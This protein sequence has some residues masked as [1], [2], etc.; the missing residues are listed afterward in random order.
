MAN[1]NSFFRANQAIKTGFNDL[2]ERYGSWIGQLFGDK[3]IAAIRSIRANQDIM[4]AGTEEQKSIAYFRKLLNTPNGTNSIPE[5]RK[6]LEEKVYNAVSNTDRK[7]AMAQRAEFDSHLQQLQR[8]AGEPLETKQSFFRSGGHLNS[9]ILGKDRAGSEAALSG[10]DTK[11]GSKIAKADRAIKDAKMS[12]K[13]I[14]ATAGGAR[15][16]GAY[17]IGATAAGVGG[18]GLGL[19][20]GY[21]F[22]NRT[23]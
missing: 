6:V 20:Y 23:R 11:V 10:F 7:A 3:D 12:N 9:R 5:A 17:G 2:T 8:I 16:L 21:D 1:V 13:K 15:V 4:K 14:E 22:L 19:G 18:A